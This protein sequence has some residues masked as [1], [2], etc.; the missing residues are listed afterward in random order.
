[1]PCWIG[2]ALVIQ[3]VFLD[4]L[5]ALSRAMANTWCQRKRPI[6]QGLEKVQE[7]NRFLA[8]APNP[9]LQD[10]LSFQSS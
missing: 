2:L 10:S 1:M 7:Q 9:V 5:G 4:F 8:L 6:L 3:H